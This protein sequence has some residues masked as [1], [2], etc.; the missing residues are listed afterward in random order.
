MAALSIYEDPLY[1]RLCPDGCAVGCEKGAEIIGELLGDLPIAKR[2][3]VKA[4]IAEWVSDLVYQESKE[5]ALQAA[6]D[7]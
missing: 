5:A 7:G 6:S 4:L 1:E 3:R 2:D